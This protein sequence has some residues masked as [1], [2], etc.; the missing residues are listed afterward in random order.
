MILVRHI[1]IFKQGIIVSWRQKRKL[2]RDKVLLRRTSVSQLHVEQMPCVRPKRTKLSANVLMGIVGTVKLDVSVIY[3]QVVVMLPA[4]PMPLVII[5]DICSFQLLTADNLSLC[6]IDIF[7]LWRLSL[8]TR[9]RC[10]ADIQKLLMNVAESNSPDLNL[11]PISTS[12]E[13]NCQKVKILKKH[14]D[15]LKSDGVKRCYRFENNTQ[16]CGKFTV[17]KPGLTYF[18]YSKSSLE[19]WLREGFL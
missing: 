8:E 4:V 1:V 7:L 15:P 17:I 13:Y 16:V 6:R 18:R 11:I 2:P 12:T 14:C 9:L 10:Y 5:V 19:N 3:S